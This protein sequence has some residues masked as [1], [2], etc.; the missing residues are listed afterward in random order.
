MIYG[1]ISHKNGDVA[2]PKQNWNKENNEEIV[3]KDKKVWDFL[4]YVKEIFN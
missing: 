4:C 3:L 1:K 2:Q